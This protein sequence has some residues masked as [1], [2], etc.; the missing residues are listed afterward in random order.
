MNILRKKPSEEKT[1]KEEEKE[2]K[3]KNKDKEYDSVKEALI[4]YGKTFA[5]VFVAVFFLS[6][7]VYINATIPSGSM[8]N[9]IMKGD[10]IF[11]NRLA[12]VMTDPERYDIII[13]EYPDYPSKTFI[14]R[15]IGLPGETV[16]IKNGNVYINGSEEPLDDSF[17]AEETEGDFGPYVVPEDSYF[18]MGDNRNNSLDSRYWDNKFVSRDQIIAKAFFR[19]W[20]LSSISLVE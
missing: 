3:K 4:D 18:V 14:K 19:Y 16:E 6:Q 20:P 2:E 9:T 12:Y 17:C 13:F 10:R 1:E 11:G 7:F 15:I 8:Q 5:I